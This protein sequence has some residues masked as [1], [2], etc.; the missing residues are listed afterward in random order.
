MNSAEF[1]PSQQS[2]KWDLAV[3]IVRLQITYFVMIANKA[4]YCSKLFH[5]LDKKNIVFKI[6]NH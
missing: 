6:G 2:N 4:N 5:Y 1:Q 3:F